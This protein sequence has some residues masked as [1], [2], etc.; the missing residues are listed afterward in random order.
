MFNGS[1]IKNRARIPLNRNINHM[2]VLEEKTILTGVESSATTATLGIVAGFANTAASTAGA[3]CKQKI[4]IRNKPKK[5]CQIA[6]NLMY[7]L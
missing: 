2:P 7:S 3:C 6:I 1:N 5:V 4:L